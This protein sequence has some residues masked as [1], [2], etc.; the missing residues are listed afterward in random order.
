MP[1]EFPTPAVIGTA[2]GRLICPIEQVYE[3]SQFMAGEPVWTHQLPRVGR[4]IEAHLRATRP[5]LVP[6]L[7]EAK[8]INRDNWQDFRDRF[9]A[10]LGSTIA[11]EP[12]TAA[13]HE[14][15]DPVSELAEKVHP[16]CII[17]IQA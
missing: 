17:T 8:G 2:T 13:E 15:I 10:R 12:M 1:K 7:D 11:L 14:R 4:E 9:I 5:D 16:D 3:V 6:T